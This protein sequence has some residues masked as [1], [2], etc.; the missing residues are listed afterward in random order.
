VRID[1][2]HHGVD[3]IDHVAVVE[4]LDAERGVQLCGTLRG[5][6]TD[7]EWTAAYAAARTAGRGCGRRRDVF[8][9]G[10]VAGGRI[11]D[12]FE[13]TARAHRASPR[14]TAFGE[15]FGRELRRRVERGPARG[16]QHGKCR[17]TSKASGSSRHGVSPFDKSLVD[18]I[19]RP[20]CPDIARCW[21][22]RRPSATVAGLSKGS[23]RPQEH[24]LYGHRS[25]QRSP[26]S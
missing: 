11:R 25:V 13:V 9:C 26:G 23:Q 6:N 8:R 12:R 16:G 3:L 14:G 1:V 17:Q 10:G 7:V 21:K 5:V 15:I 24:L 2:I 4:V 19:A 22:G 20:A 18:A